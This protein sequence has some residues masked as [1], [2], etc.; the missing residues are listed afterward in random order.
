MSRTLPTTLFI[1]LKRFLNSTRTHSKGKSSLPRAGSV[2]SGTPCLRSFGRGQRL[3]PLVIRE[4]RT[5]PL[6][7][8][9]MSGVNPEDDHRDDFLLLANVYYVL[10]QVWIWPA[11]NFP[12]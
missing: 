11:L 5:S 4:A 10:G 3:C 7:A 12:P 8:V 2:G 9:D 6:L 1:G